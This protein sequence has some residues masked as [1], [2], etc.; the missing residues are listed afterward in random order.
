MK[1][2]QIA[3]GESGRDYRELFL[4]HDI[5]IIGPS[6]AWQSLCCENLRLL[7]PKGLAMTKKRRFATVNGYK[8]IRQVFVTTRGW[9][10]QVFWIRGGR[11]REKVC[12]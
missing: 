5:M 7:R 9:A 6:R 10:L 2:W 1:V 11:R 12:F 3:T 4:D 8:K